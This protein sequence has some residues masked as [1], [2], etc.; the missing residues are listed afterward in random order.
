MG[1][2]FELKNRLK[3]LVPPD[4][5]EIGK[6][7]RPPEREQHQPS[8]EQQQLALQQQQQQ[9]EQQM[10]M[11]EIEAIFKFNGICKRQIFSI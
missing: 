11:K 9:F 7:G 6:T 8:V 1:N 4:I 2:H 5:L 10:R 3:T